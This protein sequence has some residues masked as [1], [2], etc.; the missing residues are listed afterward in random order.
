MSFLDEL[1]I[2]EEPINGPQFVIL[3]GPPKIG[4]TWL[5]SHAERP[6][7]IAVEKGVERVPGV[8]KF[9]KNNEII[10]PATTDEFFSMLQYFVKKEHDYKTIVI[11]SGMFLDKIFITDIIKQEPKVK[12]GDFMVDVQ[13]IA[14]YN[15]GQGY[16]K[17]ISVYEIRFFNALKYL[18][19]KGLDV[20]MIAHSRD[21]TVL[22]DN[23]DE[24]KKQSIDM[25]AFGQYSVPNLLSAKADSILYMTANH[26][27]KKRKNAFGTIKTVPDKEEQSEIIVHTR[28]TS[29]FYAGVR[30]EKI[31]NVQDQY[32]IDFG[33]PETSKQ[34]FRDLKL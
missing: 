27:T 17:L 22:N 19:K 28:E 26:A 7:Y 2:S 31:E 23:G 33:N 10:I 3:Y 18:H 34:L 32:L 6:F 8:G 13:S 11:D 15:Y 20:I 24:Y 14:D 29:A 21:R 4:K 12:K 5:C 16:A 30:T 1:E 9:V 25:A